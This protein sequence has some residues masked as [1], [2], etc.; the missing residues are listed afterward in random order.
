MK[1]D[2]RIKNS[3]E[4]CNCVIFIKENDPDVTTHREFNDINWHFY[5][6]GNLGDSKKTDNTRVND[7]TDLKEFV[8]EIS[9]NTLPNSWF[10]TGVYMDENDEITYDPD[11]GVKMVYPITT[12]QWNNENNLKRIS[13]Y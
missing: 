1:R 11:L 9:D 10:Q 13:L 6:I 7:P 5:G 2:P 8:V 4:F 12:A 3:M